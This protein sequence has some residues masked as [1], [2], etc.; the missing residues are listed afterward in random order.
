M[1]IVSIHQYLWP[2]CRKEERM[3]KRNTRG[4]QAGVLKV[5]ADRYGTRE[6][7]WRSF[8]IGAGVLGIRAPGA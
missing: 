8:E 5:L 6:G 4:L 3:R 1:L 7:R 2:A